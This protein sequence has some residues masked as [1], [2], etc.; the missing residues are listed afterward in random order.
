VITSS[1]LLRARN[2]DKISFVMLLR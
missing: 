1:I 2:L